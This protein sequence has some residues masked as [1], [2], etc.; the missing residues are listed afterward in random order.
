M[1]C[2]VFAASVLLIFCF[3]R[4]MPG[5]EQSTV[6]LGIALESY[7]YPYPVNFFDVEMQGQPLR[8]AYMDVPPTAQANGKTVVLFHGK[9]FGGYYW[10]NTMKRFA[11]DGYRVIAPDQIGWGKSSKPD[12][13]YSFQSLASNTLRLLDRLKVDRIILIGHSTGGMLAIRFARSYPDRV[14]SAHS[15]RSDRTRGLPVAHSAPVRR[16]LVSSRDQEHRS[17]KDSQFLLKLFRQ[18]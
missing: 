11:A 5:N 17:R 16:D 2:K 6:P 4:V 18:T 1:A 13:H 7:P 14:E 10:A 12:I 3:V 9:N 8:M 15:G